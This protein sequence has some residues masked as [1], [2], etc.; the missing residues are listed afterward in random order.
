MTAGLQGSQRTTQGISHSNWSPFTDS[1]GL[2]AICVPHLSDCISHWTSYNIAPF[3]FLPKIHVQCFCILHIQLHQCVTGIT[4]LCFHQC[5]NRTLL[6]CLPI[7]SSRYGQDWGGGLFSNIHIMAWHAVYIQAMLCTLLFTLVWPIH[8]CKVCPF[9]ALFF[10][11]LYS[12]H[13]CMRVATWWKYESGAHFTSPLWWKI[14]KVDWA[15]WKL[16]KTLNEDSKVHSTCTCTNNVVCVWESKID[17][18][19]LSLIWDHTHTCSCVF[20]ICIISVQLC[21]IPL[22]LLI[23]EILVIYPH[24]LFIPRTYTRGRVINLYKIARPRH[25]HATVGIWA[26]CTHD[27][28]AE[29]PA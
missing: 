1:A 2:Y 28:I 22:T 27:K 7:F 4:P 29:T 23:T 21:L 6:T 16:R 8:S 19:R 10:I 12:M 9:T 5:C 11:T 17:T 20:P 13:A 14:T 18:C 26:T 3:C 24:L 15:G 25:L